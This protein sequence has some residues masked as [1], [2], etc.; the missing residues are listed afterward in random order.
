MVKCC[1]KV[2]VPGKRSNRQDEN[3]AIGQREGRTDDA[4]TSPTPLTIY[5]PRKLSGM[6]EQR[7]TSHPRVSGKKG[8]RGEMEENVIET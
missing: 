6:I 1:Q 2:R 4:P 7:R 3:T 8:E 5:T